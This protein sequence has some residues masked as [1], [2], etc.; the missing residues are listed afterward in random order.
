LNSS[1]FFHWLFLVSL[2]SSFFSIFGS[3]SIATS[4]PY[5]IDLSEI[6]NGNEQLIKF[7][8][9]LMNNKRRSKNNSKLLAVSNSP[10]SYRQEFF[11]NMLIYRSECQKDCKWHI[12]LDQS[13]SGG[14]DRPIF[15]AFYCTGVN[16][17]HRSLGSVHTTLRELSLKNSIFPIEMKTKHGKT[18]VGV[19][20]VSGKTAQFCNPV[21]PPK[22]FIVDFIISG[23]PET[24]PLWMAI[25]AQSYY[26]DKYGIVLEATIHN[27]ELRIS[28][29]FDLAKYGGFDRYFSIEIYKLSQKNYKV[30]P[31]GQL[32]FTLREIS[33]VSSSGNLKYMIP[34]VAKNVRSRKWSKA[35]GEIE[36]VTITPI[37]ADE[38]YIAVKA[39]NKK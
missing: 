38:N 25:K 13:E 4:F 22:G 33:F 17:K 9:P 10:Y 36:F 18:P 23:Y 19:F 14:L 39:S 20:V 21:V 7:N 35:Q 27:G 2:R 8:E 1:F 6:N 11:P 32:L 28:H 5:H 31:I 3:P 15:V 24:N 12:D 16:G 30:S 37:P 26:S 34:N 29:D